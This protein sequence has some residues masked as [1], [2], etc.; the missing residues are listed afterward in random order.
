MVDDIEFE[1]PSFDYVRDRDFI[2]DYANRAPTEINDSVQVLRDFIDRWASAA[3][4]AGLEPNKTPL[5]DQLDEIKAALHL[6]LTGSALA[7]L[8]RALQTVD[9]WHSNECYG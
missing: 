3:Q 5:P 7:E 4:D 9:A 2:D 1:D 8:Q 6:P